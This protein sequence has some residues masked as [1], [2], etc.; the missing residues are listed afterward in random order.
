M[1]GPPGIYTLT[2]NVVDGNGCVSEQINKK[3][4]IL[5]PGELVFEAAMPSTTVCSD[6]AGGV[7][8][9]AP[10]HTESLFRVVYAGEKNLV[11]ATLTL[12]NPEGK[13]VGLN[14]TALPDQAHP[15]GNSG[16]QNEDKSID[17]SVSDGWKIPKKV[18][19]NLQ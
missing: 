1:D 4:E 12:K 15:D 8:G 11:S 3:V 19:C 18:T 6:L 9:S 17:I 14:G 10:S 5:T 13:F 16:K 2:V 7:E